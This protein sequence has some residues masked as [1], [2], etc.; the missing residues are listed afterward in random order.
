MRVSNR[1][2]KIDVDSDFQEWLDD[3]KRKV[4]DKNKDTV[5][6]RKFTKDL[7]NFFK[8]YINIEYNGKGFEINF[9]GGE[10]KE[11]K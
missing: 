2:R 5:S 6:R 8:G 9:I 3:V 7:A 1:R 4:E 10:K 11:K